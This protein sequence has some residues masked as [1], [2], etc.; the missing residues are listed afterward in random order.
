MFLKNVVKNYKY[1]KAKATIQPIQKKV[2]CRLLKK[3]KNGIS[4]SPLS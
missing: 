2:Y 4:L 3:S 1:Q